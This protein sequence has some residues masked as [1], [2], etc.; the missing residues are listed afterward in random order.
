MKSL[1]HI[2]IPV[3]LP[4]FPLRQDTLVRALCGAGGMAKEIE[5]EG[6]VY[7]LE[8]VLQTFGP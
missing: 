6:E 3:P 4:Y 1:T 5:E 7:A 8:K 2:R